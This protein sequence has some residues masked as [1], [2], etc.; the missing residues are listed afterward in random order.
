MAN[1]PKVYDF[2]MAKVEDQLVSYLKKET[3]R[4]HGGGHDCRHRPAEVPGRAGGQGGAG[5]IRRSAEG[6]RGRRPPV[7][8]SQ[9][10]AEHRPRPRPVDAPFLEGFRPG[11]GEGPFP[12]LQDLDRGHARR[13]LRRFSSPSSCWQSWPHSPQAPPIAATVAAA[14][15]GPGRR[16]RQHVPRHEPVQHAPADV[17]LV[18][19]RSATHAASR[20]GREAGPST[21]PSSASCSARGI[22]TRGGKRRS[23]ATSS[24]ISRPTRA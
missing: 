23:G 18:Q 14:A 13:L 16:V 21:S 8:L 7:L 20:S 19:P 22:R 1:A 2:P 5:R 24:P 17:V 3:R 15:D 6:D 12:A 11:R 9:R 4:I 10:H